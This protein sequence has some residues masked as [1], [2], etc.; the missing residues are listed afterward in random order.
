MQLYDVIVF[1]IIALNDSYNDCGYLQA[2]KAIHYALKNCMTNPADTEHTCHCIPYTVWLTRILDWLLSSD[3][4][5]SFLTFH[6]DNI[7]K[8]EKAAALDSFYSLKAKKKK[9]HCFPVVVLLTLPCC[10]HSIGICSLFTA[11]KTGFKHT[12][13][14][15]ELS[16]NEIFSTCNSFPGCRVYCSYSWEVPVDRSQRRVHTGDMLMEN[17][18]RENSICLAGRSSWRMTGS[19]ELPF[20]PRGRSPHVHQLGGSQC[21]S[22]LPKLHLH[23]FSA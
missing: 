9:P 12:F 15:N 18:T 1:N 3:S 16:D 23:N 6:A 14:K 19:P 4:S 22:P 7:G 2:K 11:L 17:E 13:L 21:P 20:L 8:N 10:A 5:K